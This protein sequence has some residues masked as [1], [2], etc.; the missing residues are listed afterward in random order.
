MVNDPV[1]K[2]NNEKVIGPGIAGIDKF[3]MVN[4]KTRCRGIVVVFKGE[5]AI[6]TATAESHA[7]NSKRGFILRVDIESGA[8]SCYD[9]PIYPGTENPDVLVGPR[10]R[11]RPRASAGRD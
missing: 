8:V 7:R 4:S 9:R 1:D 2:P 3:N 6:G 11:V 10:Y 5:Y